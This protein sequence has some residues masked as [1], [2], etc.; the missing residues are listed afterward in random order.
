MKQLCIVLCV[1]IVSTLPA[2]SQKKEKAKMG[3]DAMM[4]PGPLNN[5]Y[6]SWMIGEWTGSTEMNMGKT[7]DSQK[8]DWGLDSQF[9]SVEFTSKFVELKPEAVKAMAGSMKISEED[10]KNMMQKPYKG[11]GQFTLN[12]KNGEFMGYWFDNMRGVFKGTGAMKGNTMTTKWTGMRNST[13][14]MEKTG[15][16]SMTETFKETDPATGQV[17]EGTSTWTRK[18]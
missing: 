5:S 6:F 16:D 11:M 17:M 15:E 3:G 2:L 13:R 1:I 8:I 4:P 14:T 18:K 9:V 10:V 12:P 7:E